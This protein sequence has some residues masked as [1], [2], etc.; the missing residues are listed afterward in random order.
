MSQSPSKPWKKG[1]QPGY[2]AF[3]LVVNICQDADGNVWSDHDFLTPEDHTISIALPQG[4]A[5]QIAHAL[6]SE[7]VRR[8][9]FLCV[10]VEL[11]KDREFMAKWMGAGD[12][13]K[14]QM[15]T[16]LRAAVEQVVSQTLAKM[17]SG[18][19][20][21]VLAMLADQSVGSPPTDPA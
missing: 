8:E 12:A 14:D 9:A 17:A 11:T 18:A 7:A 6:L 19:V 13:A 5:P 3:Q 15:E 2:T 10:L 16:G 20:P 1:E 21:E 4:G